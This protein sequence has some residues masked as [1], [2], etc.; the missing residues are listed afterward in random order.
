MVLR[1]RES[2]F[3]ARRGNYSLLGLAGPVTDSMECGI[4]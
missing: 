4:V 1:H 2:S 3:V